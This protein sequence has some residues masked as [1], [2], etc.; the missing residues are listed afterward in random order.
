M[1]FKIAP[2]GDLKLSVIYLALLDNSN[3]YM[4]TCTPLTMS[5]F[6]FV[7]NRDLLW[8]TEVKYKLCSPKML[9]NYFFFPLLVFNSFFSFHVSLSSLCLPSYITWQASFPTFIIVPFLLKI[10]F[11]IFFLHLASSYLQ[12]LP[13]FP[14]FS[15]L[16]LFVLFSFVPSTFLISLVSISRTCRQ[17]W[18]THTLFNEYFYPVS[19][20]PSQE[21]SLQ[22]RHKKPAERQLSNCIYTLNTSVC[23][24]CQFPLYLYHNHIN[25]HGSCNI[26]KLT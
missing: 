26:R 1:T 14:F 23:Q 21:Q 3:T 4:D 7:D 24:T 11:I 13:L 18:N 9:R 10:P 12:L 22:S 19:I 6:N 8:H 2:S 17:F 20:N 5:T 25:S 16:F 15:P